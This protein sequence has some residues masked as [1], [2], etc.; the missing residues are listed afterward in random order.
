MAI[1]ATF[2]TD[3]TNI[4]DGNIV[5]DFRVRQAVTAIKNA[6]TKIGTTPATTAC[7]A[8]GGGGTYGTKVASLIAQVGNI[9]S[10]LHK[11]GLAP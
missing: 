7:I 11:S 3:I 8:P 4:N 5:H 10:A 6:L 9:I 2:A 1:N